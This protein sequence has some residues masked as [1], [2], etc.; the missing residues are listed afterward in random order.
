M[1]GHLVMSEKERARLIVMKRVHEKSS[2]LTDAAAALGLSYRQILRIH[3]RYSAE[4][5]K[6][7]V[8][9]SRGRPSPR[10]YDP[11]FKC[12]VVARYK[13]RY[14][15]FGPTLAAE[16]LAGEGYG[17]DH[18]TLRRWLLGA[19]AINRRRKSTPHR[20]RRERRQRFGELVQ[21][22]GSHHDWF[23]GRRGSCCLMNMVDDATGTTMAGFSE[24]ETTDAAMRLLWAWIDRYGIP[25]ALYVD[26]HAVYDTNRPPTID[27]ELSDEAPLTAFGKVSKKLGIRIIT[28]YSPQAKGRVERSNGVYQDR[29]VKEMR[30]LAISTID[31]A[32]ELL[33]EGFTGELN[34]KFAVEPADPKDAHVAAGGVDLEEVFCLED[35]RVVSN[36]YTVR[37]EN[38]FYQLTKQKGLPRPG[39]RVT[40]QKRLDGSIHVLHRGRKLD[41]LEIS[42]Q[43]KQKQQKAEIVLTPA[44][45]SAPITDPGKARLPA[46]DHPWRRRESKP[47]RIHALK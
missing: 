24:E 34:A 31:E 21:L 44:L 22:D 6:G 28:A 10:R 37:H 16:K 2:R 15:G 9:K 36:D 39:D 23:E 33:L 45:A 42:L 27:E 40:M 8:H 18:E 19:G 4:G 17:L 14:E 32:N 35:L 3:R 29:L 1:E 7:L 11:E 30:L 47:Q 38:C 5:D 25:S 13:E 12:A 43:V 20:S 26:R 41:H 46:K